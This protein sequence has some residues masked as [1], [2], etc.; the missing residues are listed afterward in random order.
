MDRVEFFSYYFEVESRQA[1]NKDAIVTTDNFHKLIGAY[2]FSEPVACQLTRQGGKCGRPHNKGWVGLTTSGDEVLIGGFCAN[3]HFKADTNF[4]TEKKR[5]N[6]ELEFRRYNE[7]IDD[8]LARRVEI[9]S[10][11]KKLHSNVVSLRSLQTNMLNNLPSEVCNFIKNAEK[12][13]NRKVSIELKYEEFDEETKRTHVSWVTKDV[14]SV[15]SASFI[16]L[17]T[18]GDYYKKIS[19][20]ENTFIHI[21]STADR[22]LKKIKKWCEKLSGLEQ[23]HNDVD[24]S[25]KEYQAFIALDNLKLLLLIT[26]T[27]SSRKA[28]T[29]LIHANH[30]GE[31]S[32]PDKYITHFD[33]EIRK[34]NRGRSFR[35]MRSSKSTQ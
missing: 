21:D 31:V 4:I 3:N 20:I 22:T 32:T 24:E 9:E 15:K 16:D 35:L 10:D 8:F 1:F 13:K 28:I 26:S 7:Q 33:E 11:L 30:Y 29:G 34:S 25:I 19:G 2:K 6:T 23:L 17:K 14:G 18:I 12:T 5:V 27:H